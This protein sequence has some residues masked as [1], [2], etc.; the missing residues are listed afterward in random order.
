[1]SR[2]KKSNTPKEN[3]LPD[4]RVI[5]FTGKGGVGKTSVAAA[6]SVLSS[7]LDHGTLIMSTDAAHSLSDSFDMRI[8]SEPTQIKKNLWG[9]EIDI[10]EQ[11]SRHWG[12]I[13]DF[14]TRFLKHRGF[15]SIIADELA[16][17]PGMEEIFSLLAVRHYAEDK[18]F[19]TIII[20]CAPTADTARL[21]AIPDVAQWYMEKV[22]QIERKVIKT[23]RP[24]AQRIIDA[25]LPTETVFDSVELLY[26]A[27]LG[28]RD[29][30]IDRTRTTIRMVVN[31]EK[32]VIKEAQKAYT[33]LCLFDFGIDA[34]VVNRLLPESV[35][36]PFYDKW[37]EIQTAHMAVI[38]ESFM[39]LPILTAH[40]WDEEIIGYNLLL[41]MAKEIYGK[42]DP[43]KILH[44]DK[45]IKIRS[46][47]G[48]Y[49]MEIPL[50]FAQHE[51]METWI[52][53]DELV[54][55][56]KNF[57]RNIILPRSLVKQELSKAELKDQTLTLYFEGEPNA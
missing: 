12:S 31:P 32:M 24:V 34:V 52:S 25:P 51:D 13:H 5:L 46:R 30:L 53:G 43:T 56:F 44:K 22:F 2:K 14:L 4:V 48:H 57:K 19:D 6:T 9:V 27:I 47:E 36:D 11:V 35:T 39:P 18:R 40:F 26:H 50:P 23:I 37:R 42:K 38:K 16:I 45:P 29:L 15:D 7:K 20:D 49:A 41:K 8:G 17:M 21:L 28:V 1:M 33:F 3:P 54:I 10:N 55:K